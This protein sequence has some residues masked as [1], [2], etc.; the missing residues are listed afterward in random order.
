MTRFNIDNPED[1]FDLI[2]KEPD[3]FNE[4]NNRKKMERKRCQ[5]FGVPPEID[6]AIWSKAEEQG[7]YF[8]EKLKIYQ[9]LS[10]LVLECHQ[11]I[12]QNN[13]ENNVLKI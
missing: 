13:E 6:Y 7:S 8:E 4:P 11:K 9:S 3:F 5:I 2:K 12:L 1:L 10:E